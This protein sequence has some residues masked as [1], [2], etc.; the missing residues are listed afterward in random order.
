AVDLTP[1][2]GAVPA[3]IVLVILVIAIYAAFAG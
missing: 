3:G 1:W 2:K